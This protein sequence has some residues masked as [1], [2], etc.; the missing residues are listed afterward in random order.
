MSLLL[1][2]SG[3]TAVLQA[4]PTPSEYQV[5]A[6]YLL[7]FAKFVQWPTNAFETT[8]APIIIGVLGE[9]PF[10]GNLESMIQG[11][12]VCGRPLAVKFF[13]SAKDA[14][15]KR[16][17]ILF[18]CQSERKRLNDIVTALKG[19]GVLTVSELESFLGAGGMFNFIMEANKVRFEVN[20]AAVKQSG[21]C[22]SSKLL[23]LARRKER[24]L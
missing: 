9:N 5:K 2:L 22:V 23:N 14:G 20:E 24:E 15:L 3:S 12:A 19:A 8:N 16:C 7:N 11:K 4:Q 17:Q 21:L 18:V 6:A 10:E 13:A 1:G